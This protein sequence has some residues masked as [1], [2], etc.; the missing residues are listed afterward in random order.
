[1]FGQFARSTMSN[2]GKMVRCNK[3]AMQLLL[4]T[5]RL[6]SVAPSSNTAQPEY[7]LAVLTC[8]WIGAACLLQ[9]SLF[10]YRRG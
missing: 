6:S 5:K 7:N 3:A 2:A 1:M 4:R 8:S 10:V 9:F